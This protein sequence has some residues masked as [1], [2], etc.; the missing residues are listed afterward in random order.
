MKKVF[1]TFLSLILTVSGIWTPLHADEPIVESPTQRNP[2]SPHKAPAQLPTIQNSFSPPDSHIFPR[3]GPHNIESFVD[4]LLTPTS[5]KYHA[6]LKALPPHQ[7]LTV[8]GLDLN[9]LKPTNDI[10]GHNAG[11]LAIRN[12]ME[13][14]VRTSLK[15]DYIP[16]RVGGD[17]FAMIKVGTTTPQEVQAVALEIQQAVRGR[18]FANGHMIPTS[19]S[20][21][22]AY[23][24]ES[25][26]TPLKNITLGERMN[27]E[28]DI[29][30]YE[31]K[32]FGGK[33]RVRKVEVNARGEL[34]MS[35]PPPLTRQRIR[36]FGNS[37]LRSLG[38]N[39]AF[40]AGAI[41]AEGLKSFFTG[42]TKNLS[43]LADTFTSPLFIADYTV[44]ASAYDLAERFLP[45]TPVELTLK[46][47]KTTF[48]K[49]ATRRALVLS[50]AL[51]A[52]EAVRQI[53]SLT[54]NG[55]NLFKKYV[56]ARA[57]GTEE[58]L[59][60]AE[61]ELFEAVQKAGI[62]DNLAKNGFLVVTSAG[63]AGLFGTLLRAAYAT[64][65]ATV[66]GL[67]ITSDAALLA[68]EPTGTSKVAGACIKVVEVV[69]AYL[70]YELGDKLL[71]VYER[72]TEKSN[73]IEAKAEF[74]KALFA[75][76]KA[77]KNKK[78]NPQE[79]EKKLLKFKQAL[80]KFENA[81]IHFMAY[82]TTYSAPEFASFV[83]EGEEM[84]QEVQ[85]N[86]QA[87]EQEK[88]RVLKNIVRQNL[89]NPNTNFTL[90]HTIIE[91]LDNIES[92]WTQEE[93]NYLSILLQEEMIRFEENRN[94]S[95][96]P[97]DPL[98]FLRK[99][100]SS[101]SGEDIALFGFQT[102][103]LSSF[104]KLG[105]IDRAMTLTQE[106]AEAK[107]TKLSQA[108][109]NIFQEKQKELTT[110][111][112]EAHKEKNL[113]R[114]LAFQR[115]SHARSHEP[116]LVIN[117]DNPLAQI[118]SQKSPFED[119]NSLLFGG[120]L[121][122]DPLRRGKAYS[123]RDIFEDGG[124]GV[125]VRRERRPVL[126]GVYSQDSRI[127][128]VNGKT[129]HSQSIRVALM[130]R[131]DDIYRRRDKTQ[132]ITPAGNIVAARIRNGEVEIPQP[133][134][135]SKSFRSMCEHGVVG[136]EF[137]ERMPSLSELETD[138]QQRAQGYNAHHLN[139]SPIDAIPSALSYLRFTKTTSQA[140]QSEIEAVVGKLNTLD[141]G[142]R[143]IFEK[144]SEDPFGVAMA[145]SNFA[146][147]SQENLDQT[148]A[149]EEE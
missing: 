7:T 115:E 138:A 142:I 109:S 14:I 89:N 4:E 129:G 65:E 29:G 51:L 79:Y 73:V 15:H 148:E 11:D 21:G 26:N 45:K 42:E 82:L 71:S 52:G 124:E 43:R 146:Q 58:E 2:V 116:T 97:H 32:H 130:N 8:I 23:H 36:N 9:K 69:V 3:G 31:N 132:L 120:S 34:E 46:A 20:I 121:M 66:L 47:P 81:H 144:S 104:E 117:H 56:K 133:L 59:A 22:A 40:I 136:C 92:E 27:K 35:Q 110:S 77:E 33:P 86:L 118:M 90:S 5:T 83:A 62:L 41:T 100:I 16:M 17:E 61:S 85:R 98:E 137:E 76:E 105:N 28:A 99:P 10:L 143:N 18:I 101:R 49:Q 128:I 123:G 94:N 87:L 13:K 6:H 39:G 25:S 55:E 107:I 64:A 127:E 54:K 119:L 38:H 147:S 53:M 122:G 72:Y 75:L 19:V 68:P 112:F 24:P 57:S 131:D 111:P 126:P 103:E 134:F 67:E 63:A 93:Q 102:R 95:T 125:I 78:A 145:V 140:A 106:M 91:K 80:K 139:Y 149:L 113:E 141:V 70:V 88:R 50:A 30:M 12:A 44:S 60:Q 48:F 96:Q 84:E 37:A 74:E 1:V 114:K 108:Y 135:A